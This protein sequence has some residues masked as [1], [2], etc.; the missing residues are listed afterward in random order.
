[1]VRADNGSD[2][3][4][5]GTEFDIALTWQIDRH[6]SAYIGYAHFFTGDFISETGASKDVD[7]LYA[8]VTWTF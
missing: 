8:S 4:Y 2:A 6:W 5:V 3:A 7:F 1:V